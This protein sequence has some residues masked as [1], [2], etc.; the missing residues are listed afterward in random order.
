LAAVVVIALVIRL[1]GLGWGL[2]GE[3]QFVSLHPDEFRFVDPVARSLASGEVSPEKYAYGS[4]PFDLLYGSARVLGAAGMELDSS[5]LLLIARIWSALFGA[6][7]V[8]VVG[9]LGARLGGPAVGLVAAGLLALAPGHLQHSHFATV[10]VPATFFVALALLFACRARDESR[11]AP[12]TR[13]LWIGGVAAGLAAAC[14]YPA[15]LVLVAVVAALLQLR[16]PLGKRLRASFVAAAASGVAFV[17]V[18]PWALLDWTEFWSA[19]R[20]E[21][22]E[23]QAAGH[24]EEFTGTGPGLWFLLRINLAWALGWPAALAGLAGLL[25]RLPRDPRGRALL[26]FA[27]PVLVALSLSQVRFMRYTLVLQPVLCVSAALLVEGLRLGNGARWALRSLML[28]PAATA[29]LLVLATLLRPDPRWQAEDW[30]RAQVPEGATIGLPRL[31]SFESPALVPPPAGPP[32][33]LNTSPPA[34]RRWFERQNRHGK[35]KWKGV[36]I[37]R[38]DAELL[39]REAPEW[40]VISEMRFGTALRR[41]GSK[42]R[43]FFEELEAGWERAATFDTFPP[44]WRRWF[45]VPFAPHDALYTFPQVRVYRRRGS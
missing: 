35:G 29:G 34:A 44:S 31:P 32:I 25:L 18:M 4:L 41:E 2:P 1:L 22:F 27:L 45:G 16:I 12:S 28:A 21:L 13:D 37:E 6:A 5:D 24:G 43:S 42:A 14:K 26:A 30:M 20:F 36:L 39:A 38:W 40:F 11:G 17:V 10:D 19:V 23:H 15:G 3:R 7:T 9:R 8:L 33:D